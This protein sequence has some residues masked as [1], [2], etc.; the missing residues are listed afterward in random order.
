MNGEPTRMPLGHHWDDLDFKAADM[1][2]GEDVA[3][4]SDSIIRNRIQILQVGAHFGS[5]WHV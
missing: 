4:D 5:V 3:H 2:V 1:A